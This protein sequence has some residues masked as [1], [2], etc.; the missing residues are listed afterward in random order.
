MPRARSEDR[1]DHGFR[2]ARTR[3]LVAL[4]L[5]PEGLGNA[6]GVVRFAREELFRR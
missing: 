5:A 1:I 6:S 2:I 4:G 3:S